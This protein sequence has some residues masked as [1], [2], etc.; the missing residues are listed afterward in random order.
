MK[1]SFIIIILF[2]LATCGSVLSMYK[3]LWFGVGALFFF[4]LGLDYVI[5]LVGDEE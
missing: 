4:I 3:S 5:N 1:K 2:S